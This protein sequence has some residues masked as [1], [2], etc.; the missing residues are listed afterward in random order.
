MVVISI[1]TNE[2]GFNS[3]IHFVAIKQKHLFTFIN[4]SPFLHV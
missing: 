3:L 4:V 1:T 2:Y